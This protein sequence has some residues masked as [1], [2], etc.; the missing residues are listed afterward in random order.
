M[1]G[2]WTIH[3]VR[4]LWSHHSILVL[5]LHVESIETIL[6]NDVKE[7]LRHVTRGF[8]SVLDALAR[9][10][11]TPSALN[12]VWRA[13]HGAMTCERWNT[14]ANKHIT[15][16]EFI[17]PNFEILGFNSFNNWDSKNNGQWGLLNLHLEI[18]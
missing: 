6:V 16:T 17:L 10:R 15:T 11:P 13:L 3:T 12:N 18:W 7:T 2:S 4:L 1:V 8:G 9:T 5:N 14:L